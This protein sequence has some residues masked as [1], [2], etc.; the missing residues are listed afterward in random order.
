M[1]IATNDCE[2]QS[3]LKRKIMTMMDIEYQP[4]LTTNYCLSNLSEIRNISGIMLSKAY[5]TNIPPLGLSPM[6]RFARDTFRYSEDATWR[7]VGPTAKDFYPDGKLHG[8]FVH[9]S[10][11]LPS[12]IVKKFYKGIITDHDEDKLCTEIVL[13]RAEWAREVQ[14]QLILQCGPK[15]FKYPL[16]NRLPDWAYHAYEMPYVTL[17]KVKS[18]LPV[19]ASQIDEM[20]LTPH[21]KVIEQYMYNNPATSTK[22]PP[23]LAKHLGVVPMDREAWTM[24][25]HKLNISRGM[26]DPEETLNFTHKEK[27]Y[28]IGV[29]KNIQESSTSL[30]TGPLTAKSERHLE[31]IEKAIY[32]L[33]KLLKKGSKA[34][35]SCPVIGLSDLQ[36]KRNSSDKVEDVFSTDVLLRSHN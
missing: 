35:L 15:S 6:M 27:R 32:G 20:D 36:I 5:L 29:L 24:F 13:A 17:Q 22:I 28:I 19:R 10:T 3:W 1:L 14:K 7:I 12:W 25:A 9:P 18:I 8:F 26:P 2:K 11:P 34:D 30:N 23:E 33:T 21:H 16:K 4:F 31:E